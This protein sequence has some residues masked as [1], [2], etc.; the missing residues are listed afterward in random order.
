MPAM[1][2]SSGNRSHNLHLNWRTFSI[3][4]VVS[5]IAE[6]GLLLSFVR[7]LTFS[8][9]LGMLWSAWLL[10]VIAIFLVVLKN[11]MVAAARNSSAFEI[12]ER[13]IRNNLVVAGYV[14]RVDW[15]QICRVTAYQ[16]YG[17]S[18]FHRLRVDLR[19]PLHI[20]CRRRRSPSFWLHERS[21]TKVKGQLDIGLAWYAEGP[22]D[23]LRKIRNGLAASRANEQASDG[24]Y[25][26]ASS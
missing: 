22:D 19:R 13:G 18:G 4:C 11:L 21:G 25:V 20:D 8:Q 14:G 2:P 23:I 1:S 5:I 17:S 24:P 3:C 26:T 6:G 10:F 7:S 16:D 15:E 12:D 9:G